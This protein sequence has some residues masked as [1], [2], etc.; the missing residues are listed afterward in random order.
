M[1]FRKTLKNVWE[2]AIFFCYNGFLACCDITDE[3]ASVEMMTLNLEVAL[4][5]VG[6][7]GDPM[8]L[9]L[10]GCKIFA[11]EGVREFALQ[12]PIPGV[13][14]KTKQIDLAASDPNVR[15]QWIEEI[16]RAA[17]VGAG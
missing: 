11:G 17:S 14:G 5:H 7:G 6:M 13:K 9:P 4:T 12:F 15:E 10:Q 2:P 16:Y 1:L 3:Q 8:P